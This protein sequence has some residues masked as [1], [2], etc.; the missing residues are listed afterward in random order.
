MQELRTARLRSILDDQRVSTT[1]TNI[2]VTLEVGIV[3]V[4]HVVDIQSLD[5]RLEYVGVDAED[6]LLDGLASVTHEHGHTG[7]C[8]PCAANTCVFARDVA[9]DTRVLVSAGRELV[10]NLHQLTSDTL[11]LE[12]VDGRRTGTHRVAG[13]LPRFP[14]GHLCQVFAGWQSVDVVPY[15]R[16]GS[17]TH[18]VSDGACCVVTHALA[19]AHQVRRCVTPERTGDFLEGGFEIRFAVEWVV[20]QDRLD[21][22]ATD[23]PYFAVVLL[24]WVDGL[25][26]FVHAPLDE[27]FSLYCAPELDRVDLGFGVILCC[28]D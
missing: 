8:A 24:D 11:R 26:V 6:N 25:V 16:A 12:E 14:R 19:V 13:E 9:R 22:P 5:Q 28:G 21:C 18:I 17:D 3:R 7:R 4:H 2:H 27:H 20:I 23:N 1:G 15:L 10:K